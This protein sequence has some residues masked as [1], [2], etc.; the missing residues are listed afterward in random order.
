MPSGETRVGVV[1]VTTPISATCLP[2]ATSKTWYGGRI[3]CWVVLSTTL[4]ARYGK[5]VPWNGLPVLSVQQPSTSGVTPSQAVTSSEYW[6]SVTA[7]TRYSPSVP[8]SNSWLPTDE[9]SRPIALRTSMVGSS[10][11][12][13]DSKGEALIRSPAPTNQESSLPP[14]APANALFRF[15][16]VAATC[17][18]PPTVWVLPSSST[19]VASPP[20]VS[21][22]RP[23]KS[24]IA[25][26]WTGMSASAAFAASGVA[27]TAADVATASTATR[28]RRFRR[29]G[30]LHRACGN[31]PPGGRPRGRCGEPSSQALLRKRLGRTL[32]RLVPETKSR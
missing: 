12:T 25:I 26:S 29:K 30:V 21:A 9:T 31:R 19:R 15:W 11:K 6:P 18:E 28:E 1:F 23:W 8:R 5:S 7:E 2:P 3:G 10:L 27:T 4:A 17:A 22:M 20:V 24:F 14:L 32:T 13:L 16:T